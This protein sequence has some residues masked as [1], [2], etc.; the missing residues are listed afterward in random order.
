MLTFI[1]NN[2][3]QKTTVKGQTITRLDLLVVI[4]LIYGLISGLFISEISLNNIL[5]SKWILLILVYIIASKIGTNSRAILKF[6]VL[7]GFVQAIISVLQQAGILISNNEFFHITGFMGN[8]GPLGGFQAVA[9]VSGF[10]LLAKDNGTIN[11][12]HIAATYIIVVLISY[13]VLLSESR[14]SILSMMSGMIFLYWR[15]I[16]QTLIRHKWLLCLVLILSVLI[17]FLMV[18][19]R[20]ESVMARLMIWRVSLNMFLDNFMTGI[21]I[22]RFP[23]EYMLYQAEFFETHPDSSFVMVADNVVYAYNELLQII[24]EQGICGFIIISAI[25]YTI[26]WYAGERQ[27]LPSFLTLLVFSLFSYPTHKVGLMLLFPIFAGAAGC[28]QTTF[29]ITSKTVHIIFGSL[30]ISL[31][32]YASINIICSK[33]ELKELLSGNKPCDN[34]PRRLFLKSYTDIK[35]NAIFANVLHNQHNCI[36]MEYTEKLFP[37]CETWCDIGQMKEENG[38]LSAAERYYKTA[39]YMIPSRVRPKYLLWKLYLNHGRKSEAK[40]LANTI[41]SQPLKTENTFTLRVKQEIKDEYEL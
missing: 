31:A 6:T 10:A 11:R 15:N 30:C 41:L 24:V 21:G 22:A 16:K 40:K 4:S 32:A 39:S 3:E 9:A 2:L 27:I 33:T 23:M 1:T 35:S 17:I 36:A 28:S 34:N 7:A 29:N 5:Y 13:S 38:E 14:A 18:A 20:P 26:F 25:I 19:C 8:P 37:T 12:K